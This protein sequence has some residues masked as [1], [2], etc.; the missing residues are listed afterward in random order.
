MRAAPILCVAASLLATSCRGGHHTAKPATATNS[1]PASAP[2]SAPTTA[3]P[4]DLVITVAAGP[5]LPAPVSRVVALVDGDSVVLLGGEPASGGSSAGVIRVDPATGRGTSIGTLGQATHDAAGAVVN[6]AFVVF[7]GGEQHTID[8]GQSIAPGQPARVVGHLP[9]PRS[10]VV[11]A[12]VDDHTYLLGGYD[13]TRA[14]PDVLDTTDAVHFTVLTKLPVPVR[15]AAVAV[16]GHRIWLF[17]GEA[18]GG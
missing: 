5:S 17:G 16:T 11:A 8:A 14:T 7:G 12:T 15:Y 4:V 1:K 10:D 18:A 13:G 2:S 3:A 9:Q 6:G